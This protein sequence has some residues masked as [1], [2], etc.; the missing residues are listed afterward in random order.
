M[1]SM[2]LPDDAASALPEVERH[3]HLVF[4]IGGERCALPLSRVREVVRRPGL[5]RVPLSP[6]C[7]DGL[8]NLRGTVTAVV[9]LHDLLGLDR[10]G[11]AAAGIGDAARVV[12]IEHETPV[13][14][15]AD[16]MRGIVD[17]DPGRIERGSGGMEDARRS[18][19]VAGL[20]RGDDGDPSVL[21]L[22]PD[23]GLRQ[24]FE[25][26]KAAPRRAGAA[27]A[28]AAAVPSSGPA[29]ERRER[30]LVSFDVEGQEYALPLG[31]VREIVRA[32]DAVA[33]I[34]HAGGR[35]AGVMTL[36]GRLLPLVSARALLGLAPS[37]GED[38]HARVVV[39]SPDGE[40]LV[41][42]VVDRARDILR[43]GEE[44]VD[45]VPALLDRDAGGEIEAIGRLDEGRRLVSIL[46]PRRMLN[47]DAGIKALEP[48]SREQDEAMPE[49]QAGTETEQFIVFRLDGGEYGLP[50]DGVEE[51]IRVPDRPTRVP[52]APSFLAGVIGWRG[53]VLPVVDQRRRFE[54]P[55][56]GAAQRRHAVVLAVGPL[57]IGL[58]VDAVTAV[59]RIPRSVIDQT[60]DYP[61][62]RSGLVS[63]VANLDGRMILLLAPELLLTGDEISR[64][65][66]I[67][68]EG[69]AEDVE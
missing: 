40:A 37:S 20:L 65:A 61:G 28:G 52:G 64:L 59:L 69:M 17:I 21:I 43:V 68:S 35:V 51:I 41:G 26:V 5:V 36:R 33:R 62:G 27:V 14:L 23:L 12:V 39:L 29:A 47:G 46:A 58:Q 42:L 10:D 60:P 4:E 50:V 56:A 6:R 48:P 30:L 13:G 66:E 44:K 19:I 16:R 34:P 24:A 57:R 49:L 45:A 2:T 18:D 38:G 67:V 7:L 9:A 31:V 54:L 3:A 11:T 15:S 32:P 53:R 22:D 63:R 8:A 55:E 1:P 25:A